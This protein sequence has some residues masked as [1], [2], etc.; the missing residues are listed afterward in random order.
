MIHP[1]RGDVFPQLV[2]LPP[3]ALRFVLPVALGFSLLF[4]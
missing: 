3:A 2:S 4:L 1:R